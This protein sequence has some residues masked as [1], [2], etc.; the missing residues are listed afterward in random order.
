MLPKA[1]NINST[2][3]ASSSPPASCLTW[4]PP[5]EEILHRVSNAHS[6]TI[7]TARRTTTSHTRGKT[8]ASLIDAS[9]TLSANVLVVLT[10][11]VNLSFGG[12]VFIAKSACHTISQTAPAVL[13][14]KEDIKPTSTCMI[15]FIDENDAR[16]LH[17]IQQPR[18]LFSLTLLFQLACR[19][20]V[21]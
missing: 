21:P 1:T 3:K 19:C 16:R 6:P 4:T 13:L 11:F 7:P 17:I 8:L 14:P 5:L 2:T 18:R 9:Q 20:D 12:L 10:G 15:T